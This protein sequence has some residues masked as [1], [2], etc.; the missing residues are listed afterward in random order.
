M[1]L[2]PR[3]KVSARAWGVVATTARITASAAR[4]RGMVALLKGP[5]SDS[6]RGWSATPMASRGIAVSGALC[7]FGEGWV[8]V[9]LAVSPEP[10]WSVYAPPIQGIRS[11][12]NFF[13]GVALALHRRGVSR[14][15][16]GQPHVGRRRRARGRGAPVHRGRLRARRR[17]RRAVDHRPGIGLPGG[18]R[19]C[20]GAHQGLKAAIAAPGAVR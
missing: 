19:A 9:P 20:A 18:A 4:K 16:P 6:E 3:M 17:A 14:V 7:V 10:R 12:T 2:P 13:E 11:A 8:G 5:M 1:M 15:S